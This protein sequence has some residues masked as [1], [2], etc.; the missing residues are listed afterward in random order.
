MTANIFRGFNFRGLT[1]S[2]KHKEPQTSLPQKGTQKNQVA[3]TPDKKNTAVTQQ[4]GRYQNS[5]ETGKQVN[6]N[7]N[8]TF[9]H[10]DTSDLFTPNA[11]NSKGAKLLGKMP[12]VT[13]T[14]GSFEKSVAAHR[15]QGAFSSAGGLVQGQGSYSLAEAMVKGSGKVSFEGGALKATGSLEAAATL[16]RAQGS[17]RVGKGDYTLDA[18]G[19]AYVGAVARAN[20]E[21]VI[22]PAK[23]IYAAKIEA[24][25]FVGARAGVEANVNL[26]KF[27]SVGGSAEAWAGVGVAFKAEAGFKNGRFKA[28]LDIGAALGIG[29]KLGVNIDIDFKGIKDTIKK[30]VEKPVE[31]VKSIIEKPVEMVKEAAQSVSKFFKSLF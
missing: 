25:A 20:G 7:Y 26:G 8:K 19:E 24:D 23:G 22:D 15:G 29:F 21:M 3:T 13:L 5:F 27:G 31:M 4:N 12:G 16:A 30:V 10:G 14:E 1:Q 18:K 11:N 2:L 9:S 6:R 28:R 17:I